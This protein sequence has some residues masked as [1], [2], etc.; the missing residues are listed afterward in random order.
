MPLCE[1][2]VAY[3]DR[4]KSLPRRFAHALFTGMRTMV[5]ANGHLHQLQQ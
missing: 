5:S 3:R 2:Q 1:L 4:S